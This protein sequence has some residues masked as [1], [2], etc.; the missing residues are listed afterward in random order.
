MSSETTTSGELEFEDADF[1]EASEIVPAADRN[2]PTVTDGR[3]AGAPR[4]LVRT[5]ILLP[6]VFLTVTLFGGMRFAS[7]DNAFV[8]VPP[9]LLCLVFAAILMVLYFRG[10]M[11]GLDGWFSDDFAGLK[12]AANGAVFLTVFTGSV[13]LFN[14][15]L[16][17]RGIPFWIAGFCIFWMLW[18][19][20]F[21]DFDGK[22]LVKSLGA[23]FA[24]LFATKYLILANLTAPAG[25]GWL[26]SI[27]ENPSKEAVTWL[28][29]L[30]RFSAAT[31][32]LQFFTVVMYLVGL[33]ML[34]RS[35]RSKDI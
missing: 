19:Y 24:V 10:G 22:R 26:R 17:E 9:A 23:A 28:L 11:I 12:N 3:S 31:G 32:Y 8:F 5:Y 20:L 18:T 16:P 2:L 6:L 7:P 30:P 1:V 25:D 27:I 14:S 15:L 34:P 33:F 29:D 35:T 21:A 13:Q 4:R